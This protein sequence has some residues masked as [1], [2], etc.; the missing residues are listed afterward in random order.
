MKNYIAYYRVS[1]QK[2]GV[3][4]LGLEAQSEAVTKFTNNCDSC[5]IAKY[6]DIESGK[7]D[8]R[9]ELQKAILHSKKTGAQLLIAKLDRLS[10]NAAFVLELKNSGV[11]FICCDMPE[12]NSLTIGIM[13][14]FAQQERE[15]ISSR[16]KA[17]LNAKKERDGEWRK[18]KITKETH[19]KGQ[20]AIKEKAANNQNT[21][22]ARNYVRALKSQGMTLQEIADR[23]NSEGHL[24]SI[25]KQYHRT[26]VKRLLCE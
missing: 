16:T 15:M 19:S 24:T 12:A 7:N 9:Q 13:A 21:L 20:L 11:D 14:I 25:G 6:T 1:T 4:G 3:S 10:R 18:G 17:A 5:I 26:S 2:Q 22:R 8:S 23:L